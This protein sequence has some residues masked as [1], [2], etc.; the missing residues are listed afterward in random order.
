MLSHGA[1][2][3]QASYKF[4]QMNPLCFNLQTL[5]INLSSI[6]IPYRRRNPPHQLTP[7]FL[8]FGSTMIQFVDTHSDI[9]MAYCAIVL[10]RYGIDVENC[11]PLNTSLTTYC[12]KGLFISDTCEHSKRSETN[13]PTQPVQK[14]KKLSFIV[15]WTRWISPRINVFINGIFY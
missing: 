1:F 9:G 11:V 3:Q 6:V 15:E 12:P 4:L 5:F 14:F 8:V 10:S 7:I 2:P 13:C